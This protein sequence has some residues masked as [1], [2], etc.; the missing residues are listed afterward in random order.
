MKKSY[1]FTETRKQVKKILTIFVLEKM[2]L[3]I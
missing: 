3:I 1:Y 2:T